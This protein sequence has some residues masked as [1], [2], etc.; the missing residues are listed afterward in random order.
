MLL[1]KGGRLGPSIG[2]E[3]A[4]DLRNMSLYAFPCQ[5]DSVV[6]LLSHGAHENLN[7]EVNSYSPFPSPSHTNTSS[8]KLIF[9]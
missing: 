4:A 9:Q 8:K 3:G 7:P 5:E 2:A 6:F 1:K